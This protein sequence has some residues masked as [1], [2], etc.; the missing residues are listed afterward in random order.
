MAEQAVKYI[1]VALSAAAI[2]AAVAFI[3]S[4]YLL[5]RRADRKADDLH[6]AVHA[7]SLQDLAAAIV[8]CDAPAAP[9]AARPGAMRRDAAFCENVAREL[10][11]RPLEI[12]KVKPAGAA[13]T[14]APA[15]R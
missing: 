14:A 8:R 15:P 2:L 10:D 7:M 12:V 5:T 1:V 11:D 9:G 6:S 3:G 4:G 13:P